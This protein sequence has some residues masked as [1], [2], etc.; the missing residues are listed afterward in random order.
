MK[1]IIVK[2]TDSI[3]IVKR[4]YST[5]YF[6]VVSTP[7]AIFNHNRKTYVLQSVLVP[8]EEGSNSIVITLTPQ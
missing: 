3:D 2:F 5:E 6:L 7:K 8:I 4:Q 1:Y